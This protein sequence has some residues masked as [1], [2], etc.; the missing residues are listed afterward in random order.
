[1]DITSSTDLLKYLS[2]RAE[3]GEK[4]W[5]GR[6]QQKITAIQLAHQIAARHADKMTPVQIAEYVV[7]LNNQIFKKIIVGNE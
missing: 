4:Q 2:D 7:T 3:S 1:M 5:F 6:M